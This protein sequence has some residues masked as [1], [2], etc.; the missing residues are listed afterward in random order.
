MEARRDEAPAP[1]NERNEFAELMRSVREGSED[2]ARMLFDRYAPHIR[3]VVRRKLHQRLRPQFDSVDFVQ[4]VWASF[5]ALQGRQAS[6]ESPEAL[7]GFLSNMAYHK[8]IDA[9]R[10]NMQT[11]KRDIGRERPLEKLIN[12]QDE[13]LTARQPTPS[14]VFGA[15]EQWDQLLDRVPERYWPILKLLREGETHEEIAR[16][17][18]LDK[19]TV[20]RVLRRIAPESGHEPE[21]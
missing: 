20:Q 21:Q 13:R 10:Q 1:E 11:K 18:G 19:K 5:F 2:A 9:V 4:D 7:I 3:R 6:F 17:L 16:K 15:K 8:V 14:Q 12:T